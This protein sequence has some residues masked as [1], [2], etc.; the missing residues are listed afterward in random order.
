MN[1]ITVINNGLFRFK[2]RLIH[3]LVSTKII[4]PT[5]QDLGLDSSKPIV[6]A[7]QY[8][9][10][11]QELV[12]DKVITEAGLPSVLDS[13]IGEQQKNIRDSNGY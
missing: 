10:N 11:G 12:I 13:H 7:L 8:K 4:G 5:A 3:T 9:S 2:Q 6:Y 1:L